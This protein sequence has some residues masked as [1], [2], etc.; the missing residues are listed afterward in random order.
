MCFV[1]YEYLEGG[2][3]TEKKTTKTKQNKETSDVFLSISLEW[4][5]NVLFGT[6]IA[7]GLG[8]AL[9]RNAFR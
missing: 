7:V 8:L 9:F 2:R 4:L 6:E 1:F 5:N 3:G